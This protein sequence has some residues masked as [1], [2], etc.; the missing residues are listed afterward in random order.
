MIKY[1]NFLELEIQANFL[2]LE[3]IAIT[4]GSYLN[5]LSL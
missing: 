3:I 1:K 2:E 5:K 4:S